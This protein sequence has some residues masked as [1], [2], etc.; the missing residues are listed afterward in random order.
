MAGNVWEWCEDWY[1]GDYTSAPTNGSAWVSPTGSNR[2]LRGGAFDLGP[3]FLRS[4]FRDYNTPGDRGAAN[5]V[6]CL[7]P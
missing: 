2:V 5:G 4:A 3:S 6:R 7:R 1:H